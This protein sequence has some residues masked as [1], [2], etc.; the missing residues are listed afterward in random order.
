MISK[1]LIDILACPICKQEV[2][3]YNT[4]KLVCMKCKKYYPIKD[5]IPIMLIDK[6]K[7]WLGDNKEE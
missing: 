4:D 1:E 5:D 3:L 7:D 2:I 6:A